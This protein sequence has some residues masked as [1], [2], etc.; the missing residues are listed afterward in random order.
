MITPVHN[1]L[2]DFC[3][4]TNIIITSRSL[5]LLAFYH[6]LVV[7]HHQ[8]RAFQEL[9]LILG[10]LLSNP[11]QPAVKKVCSPQ[12]GYGEKRCEIQGGGQEMAV[13]VG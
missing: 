12:K 6:S 3:T 8:S 10:L 9:W 5:L 7:R 2:F 13:M 11:K 1:N 4:V